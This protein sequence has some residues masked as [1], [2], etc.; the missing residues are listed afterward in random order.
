MIL[1]GNAMADSSPSSAAEQPP[2]PSPHGDS[3]PLQPGWS[4]PK[5]EHVPRPTYYPMIMG[6]GIT[7]VGWGGITTLIISI[8]GLLLFGIA[9]AGWIGEIRHEHE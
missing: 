4:S 6:L 5:P 1:E 9:L 7:L 3:A 8:V 2:A